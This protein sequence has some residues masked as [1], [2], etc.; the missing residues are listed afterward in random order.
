MNLKKMIDKKICVVF[1]FDYTLYDALMLKELM[2]ERLSR[3]FGESF[4][5]FSKRAIEAYDKTRK[6]G[7]FHP[8]LFSKELLITSKKPVELEVILD[9]V[10][11][12]AESKACFYPETI[13]VLKKLGEV[14]NLAIFST[15]EERFFQT[16]FAPIKDFFRND[17]VFVSRNKEEIV[18]KINSL[19]NFQSVLLVDDL[20]EILQKIKENN[21]KICT[22]WMRRG[23][24]AMAISEPKFVPDFRIDM[25]DELFPVVKKLI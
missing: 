10:Y 4:L 19:A 25:L 12:T 11:N 5:E 23:P 2:Y 15:N 8:E 21:R 20:I 3:L 9:I 1:D 7:Y 6:I 24:Y 18:S 13:E 14:A 16:K 22:V 17:L